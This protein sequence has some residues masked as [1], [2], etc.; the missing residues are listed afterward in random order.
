[1]NIIEVASVWILDNSPY[2]LQQNE[3]V[4]M[5]SIQMAIKDKQTVKYYLMTMNDNYHFLPMAKKQRKT[6]WIK[7]ETCFT[8]RWSF[9]SVHWL[10]STFI[11]YKTKIKITVVALRKLASRINLQI[12]KKNIYYICVVTFKNLVKTT[13]KFLRYYVILPNKC[14]HFGFMYSLII[15]VNK[16]IIIFVLRF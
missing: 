6:S 11:K 10:G 9:T 12:Y 16:I 1:M 7:V 14:I 2:S 15:F 4:P 8:T 13:Y 5:L 3:I